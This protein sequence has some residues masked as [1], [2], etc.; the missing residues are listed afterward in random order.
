MDHALGSG[1]DP[2]VVGGQL[3]A[4]LDRVADWSRRD[5]ARLFGRALVMAAGAHRP[6]PRFR[7]RPRL[8]VVQ[9]EQVGRALCWLLDQT[10]VEHEV[11]P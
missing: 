3:A 4:A 5:R 9:A 8:S 1:G 2:D 6:G 7:Y 10:D 11:R